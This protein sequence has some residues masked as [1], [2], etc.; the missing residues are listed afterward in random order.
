MGI[1]LLHLDMGI[2][3]Q[4]RVSGVRGSLWGPYLE[5]VSPDQVEGD[6]ANTC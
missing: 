2:R 4:G 6:G 5:S 1:S 3:H